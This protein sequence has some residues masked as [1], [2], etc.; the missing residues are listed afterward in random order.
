MK[1]KLQTKTLKDALARVANIP[2]ANSTSI[3][4]QAV[5][6]TADLAGLTIMRFTSEAKIVVTIDEEIEVSESDDEPSVNHAALTQ[7]VNVCKGKDVNLH[8]DEKFLH[9]A[10][11]RA[12][13][14]LKVFDKDIMIDPPEPE[15]ETEHCNIL[16]EDISELL[17]FVLPAAAKDK[18]LAGVN[19]KGTHGSG[20]SFTATDS[21]RCYV[22][23]A[24][25]DLQVNCTIPVEG[26]ASILKAIGPSKG[27]ATISISET[28][29]TVS[30]STLE[31]STALLTDPYPD[32]VSKLVAQ[33]EPSI[34]SKVRVNRDELTE[35]LEDCASV[36]ETD[37]IVNFRV[38]K[39]TLEII[40]SNTSEAGG[41]VT[42][43][44][45]ATETSYVGVP[46][47]DMAAVF[48]KI[49][50]KDG[51]L[52]ILQTDRAMLVRQPERIAFFALAQPRNID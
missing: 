30:S 42:L 39:K 2:G 8:S 49:K 6:L 13:W 31:I 29:A 51:M 7:L 33:I 16:L 44:C 26:V 46:G 9:L 3:H 34:K 22:A 27:A 35:A 41:V 24:P 52:E 28:F 40:G 50:V 4:T 17:S 32:S 19:I 14:K 15:L 23:M 11:G 18:T 20:L 25:Y 21:K 36:N 12:K 45:E 5:K 43:D 37:R 47:A 48:K 10:S 38:N 1:L